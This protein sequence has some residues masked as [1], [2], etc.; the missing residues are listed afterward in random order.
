MISNYIA[1]VQVLQNEMILVTRDLCYLFCYIV[2]G[3]QDYAIAWYF[4]C[5]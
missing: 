4:V 1:N 3:L 2:M 5:L